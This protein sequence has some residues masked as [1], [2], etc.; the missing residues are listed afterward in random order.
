MTV[1][2]YGLDEIVVVV[3]NDQR[4]NS[5]RQWHNNSWKH[6]HNRRSKATNFVTHTHTHAN[7]LLP[8]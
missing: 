3:Q 1:G 5:S 6:E 2:G 7:T 4:I 8:K